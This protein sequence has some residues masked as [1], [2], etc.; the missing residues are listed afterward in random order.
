MTGVLLARSAALCK[1]R[2]EDFGVSCAHVLLT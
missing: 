2:H 1:M